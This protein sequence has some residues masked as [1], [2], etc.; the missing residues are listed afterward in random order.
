LSISPIDFTARAGR[1]SAG[2]KLLV[3]DRRPDA[4]RS[5][6]DGEEDG[7]GEELDPD[8]ALCG[9]EGLAQPD[10]GAAFEDGDDHDVGDADC[11]DEKSEGGVRRRPDGTLS[12]MADVYKELTVANASGWSRWL[13]KHGAESPGVWLVLA[14]KGVTQPTSLTYDEA[15]AEAIC[16]GWVDGQLA[17]GDERTFRR[18]F[19]P[20]RPGSAWSKRNVALASRL[21]D[22]GRMKPAGLDAVQ[23]AKADGSWD[24]AYEG[25]RSITVPPDLAA[26]L[27]ATPAAQEMFDRLDATNRYAVL[28]RV[29]TAKRTETRQRR[30]EQFVTMLARGETI[31]PQRQRR[32]PATKSE[33]HR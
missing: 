16:H 21:T 24:D 30:I 5:A 33:V 28:Y 32:V 9:A 7:F 6:G 4:S 2:R 26:A 15:L 11:P 3:P 22:A 29:T 31:H 12:R 1:F 14:K 17:Q 23:R 8:V 13:G 27:L 20:R 10:L 18:K 19:T 25:Q